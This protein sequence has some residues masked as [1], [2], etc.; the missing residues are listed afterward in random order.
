MSE[1][2]VVLLFALAVVLF[3]Y[4]KASARAKHVDPLTRMLADVAHK[5]AKLTVDGEG[6]IT[7]T[8]LK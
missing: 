1:L 2:E 8:A 3:C 7:Y 4:F 5:R 6:K